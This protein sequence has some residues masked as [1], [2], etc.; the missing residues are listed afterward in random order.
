MPELELGDSIFGKCDGTEHVLA[1]RDPLSLLDVV[2][3]VYM[4]DV[5][6]L[7][8]AVSIADVL[9]EET[10]VRARCEHLVGDRR[11]PIE[12]RNFTF[13]R[14]PGQELNLCRLSILPG[15]EDFNCAVSVTHGEVIFV[16]GIIGYMFPLYNIHLIELTS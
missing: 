3:L 13:I 15:I 6:G 2:R 12:P 4:E 9:T 16:Q 1:A 8:S 5:P 11:V 7:L 14:H 10:A